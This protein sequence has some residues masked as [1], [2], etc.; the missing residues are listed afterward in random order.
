MPFLDPVA[1]SLYNSGWRAQ[2][3]DYLASRRR[4]NRLEKQDY[5]S[6]LKLGPCKDCGK[7]SIKEARTF[8]HRPDEQKKF[9]IYRLANHPT[10]NLDKLI[11]EIQKCD[12]VCVGYHRDRS[13]SR[14]TPYVICC[15]PHRRVGQVQGCKGCTHYYSLSRLRAKRLWL[16][17]SYKNRP[18]KD[19]GIIFEPW[20]MDLDH[21]FDKVDTVSNLVG[22]QASLERILT[23]LEKCEVVCCWCHVARTVSR[24]ENLDGKR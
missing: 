16:V 2:N 12:L 14:L 7:H 13:Q 21:L 22:S 4:K 19:C 11:S 6:T 9:D 17:R 20:K 3:A 5:L 10:A 15:R 24:R 8:D 1:K 23:E 18:C